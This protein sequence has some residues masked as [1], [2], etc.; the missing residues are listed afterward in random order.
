MGVELQHGNK[1]QPKVKTIVHPILP[2]K[3]KKQKKQK[4]RRNKEL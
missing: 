2:K 1:H 4:K 3:Q